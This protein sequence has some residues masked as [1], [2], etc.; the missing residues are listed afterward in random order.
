[1]YTYDSLYIPILLKLYTYNSVFFKKEVVC[2]RHQTL[3]PYTCYDPSPPPP[4]QPFKNRSLLIDWNF[5][6]FA[7]DVKQLQR[8][9]KKL[10]SNNNGWLTIQEFSLVL[11]LCDVNVDEEES[12]QLLTELDKGMNGRVNYNEFLKKLNST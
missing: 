7:G 4:P 1:M 12:F 8:A 3:L 6:Q 5:F 11:R 10:D 9:F 2:W